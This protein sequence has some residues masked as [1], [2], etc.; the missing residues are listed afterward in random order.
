MGASIKSERMTL[1][2]ASDLLT[3]WLP[4][5]AGTEATKAWSVVRAYLSC[6]AEPVGELV[7]LGSSP[8]T[9][10]YGSVFWRDNTPPPCGTK[11]YAHPSEDARDAKR[12]RWLSEHENADLYMENPGKDALDAAVDA[13]MAKENGNV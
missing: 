8:Y 2:Q 9:G 5:C 7:R 4:I 3:E 12:Y 6:A 1:E 13:A 11:L 10:E